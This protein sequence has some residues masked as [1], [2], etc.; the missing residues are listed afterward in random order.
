[1]KWC[2]ESNENKKNVEKGRPDTNMSR[3]EDLMPPSFVVSTHVHNKTKHTHVSDYFLVVWARSNSYKTIKWHLWRGSIGFLFFFR[4]FGFWWGGTA[5]LESPLL[6]YN[7]PCKYIW[8]VRERWNNNELCLLMSPSY[9]L[10]SSRT[11][12]SSLF[13]FIYLCLDETSSSL[14]DILIDIK[15]FQIQNSQMSALRPNTLNSL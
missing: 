9:L 4:F 14:C 10:S 11:A 3:E 12:P 1:M 6:L 7:L 15:S 8:L 13:P 2:I 5:A